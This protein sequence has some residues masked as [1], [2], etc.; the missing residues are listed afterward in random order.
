MK[1]ILQ[2]SYGPYNKGLQQHRNQKIDRR[3]ILGSTDCIFSQ[4]LTD[5]LDHYYLVMFLRYIILQI[6]CSLCNK[7]YTSL[8]S[9]HNSDIV[10]WLANKF[11]QNPYRIL[12]YILNINDYHIIYN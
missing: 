5:N 1:D 2:V 9:Y 3:S 6:D 8:F 12:D 4:I 11:L 10:D 7:T